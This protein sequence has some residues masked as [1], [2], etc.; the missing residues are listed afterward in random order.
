MP[1]RN[2]VCK[3]EGERWTRDILDESL[4]RDLDIGPCRNSKR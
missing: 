2:L 1:G 3:L 4:D